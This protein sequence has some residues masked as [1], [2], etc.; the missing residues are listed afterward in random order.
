MSTIY[1]RLTDQGTA[2]AET[3]VCE[4]HRDHAPEGG[5]GDVPFGPLVDCTGND[6]L[7]CIEC[8]WSPDGAATGH[9]FTATLAV[10]GYCKT[11][12]CADFVHGQG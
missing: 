9:R 3:A 4:N 12:G 5:Y 6:E 10:P 1:A 2:A 7:R 11:C 8:G